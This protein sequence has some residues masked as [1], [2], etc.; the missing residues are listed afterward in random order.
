MPDAHTNGKADGDDEDI[1]VGKEDLVIR[2]VSINVCMQS[3]V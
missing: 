1:I 3:L 2:V